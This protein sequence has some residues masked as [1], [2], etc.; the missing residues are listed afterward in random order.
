MLRQQR[1]R[2]DAGNLEQLRRT[3]RASGQDDLSGRIRCAE[4]VVSPE[5]DACT[6]FAI[7]AKRFDM[8]VREYA[9]VRPEHHRSQKGPRRRPATSVSDRSLI[10][11]HTV[12][13]AS[14]EV[15]GFGEPAIEC[16]LLPG[17]YDLPPIGIIR[18]VLFTTCTVCRMA[19][20]S[21]MLLYAAEERQHFIPG[22]AG[23]SELTPDIVVAR[24]PANV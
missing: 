19:A 8:G 2:A 5:L 6:A 21:W 12:I 11:S 4:G 16:S 9:K 23:I 13:R 14:I 20:T 15:L 7:K 24:L 18:H 10:I 22:P 1:R 3:N 17:F